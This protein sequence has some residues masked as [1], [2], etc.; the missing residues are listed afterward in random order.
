MDYKEGV[1]SGAMSPELSGRFDAIDRVHQEIAGRGAVVTS[2][3]DG[4][5]RVNSKH[6]SGEAIDLRTR[7]LTSSQVDRLVNELRRT[8]GSDFDVIREGDHIHLEYDP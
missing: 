4:S 3:R 5:H 8:L 7:D 6:Y 1:D 2:A